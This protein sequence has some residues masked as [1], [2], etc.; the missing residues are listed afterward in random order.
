MDEMRA[1]AQYISRPGF[2]ILVRNKDCTVHQVFVM[3]E[4]LFL[5]TQDF[6]AQAAAWSLAV[7]NPAI[8]VGV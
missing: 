3:Q 1:T 4:R 6:H 5:V 7:S 8:T 2:G